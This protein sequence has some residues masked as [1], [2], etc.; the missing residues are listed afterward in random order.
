MHNLV[1]NQNGVFTYRKSISGSSIRVSLQTKDKFEA[2]RVVDKVNSVVEL[3]ASN[4]PSRVRSIIYAA[5]CK[6]QPEFKKER[7]ELVQSLLGVSLEQNA[8]ELLS[9]VIERF[10][11]EKLRSNS[12]TDKT[13]ITYKA[14]YQD[15]AEFI[16][17]KGIKTVSHQDAQAIKNSLQCLP[18][19]RN[20]RAMYKGKTINRCSK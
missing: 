4:E 5:L 16:G 11:D 2:L 7:L 17:N 9:V 10:I 12:W 18:S 15:L 13:Y 20:K 1:V 8:S 14:I 6:F 19:G 3:A